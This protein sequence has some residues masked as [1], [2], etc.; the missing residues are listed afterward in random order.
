MNQHDELEKL[1][2]LLDEKILFLRR[3]KIVATDAAT[4]FGLNKKIEEAEAERS[5]IAEQMENLNTVAGSDKLY[6]ALLKLG[7]KEQVLSFKKFIKGLS[8]GAFL[9][10]GSLDYGQGWLLN[11]LVTQ[12]VRHGTMGKKVVIQLDRIA[13]RRDIGALWRELGGRVGLRGEHTPSDIVQRVFQ[14]WK[15]Q[16]VILVFH[17]VDCMP[18][19]YLQELVEEFW[20]PLASQAR[21]SPSPTKYQLLMFLVDYEGCVGCQDTMFVEQI[22]PTWEPKIPIKLPSITPFE[23]RVLIDWIET[24]Q[25]EFDTLPLVEIINEIED[26]AK[27]ILQKSNNGIP[28]LAISEICYM[29][30]S[31][32]YEEKERWLK[33]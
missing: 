30:G 33:L 7:Y 32:W 29:C 25:M 11:R 20:L 23:D 6:N 17:D 18:E 26:L 5:E 28:E 27:E 24:V 8:I 4:I 3:E 1:L 10:H 15:T 21:A 9:I 14:W 13:R 12:H 22:E 19:S 2:N 16:N 31:N